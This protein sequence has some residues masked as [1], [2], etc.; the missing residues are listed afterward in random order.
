MKNAR[1]CVLKSA[2]VVVFFF[3]FIL[4]LFVFHMLSKSRKYCSLSKARTFFFCFCYLVYTLKR[5]NDGSLEVEKNMG[6][7]G[8]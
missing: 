7:S 2:S 4:E 6:S 8:I 1:S 3:F 5:A